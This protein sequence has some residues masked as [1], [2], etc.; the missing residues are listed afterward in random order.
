MLLLRF[1]CNRIKI[2]Q[3]GVICAYQG[4]R[5]KIEGKSKIL[6]YLFFLNVNALY[7]L[8]NVFTKTSYS[9]QPNIIIMHSSFHISPI[10]HALLYGLQK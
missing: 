4:E 3:V 1:D 2:N 9:I 5:F 8:T 7:R 10:Y 6:S